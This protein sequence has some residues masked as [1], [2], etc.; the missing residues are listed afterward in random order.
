MPLTRRLSSAT[1]RDK[2]D[3]DKTDMAATYREARHHGP[4]VLHQ[5]MEVVAA[6][7]PV[8]DVHTVLDLGCGTGRYSEGLATRLD[9]DVI[10]ID[11]S[12]KMLGDARQNLR[13]PRVFYAGGSAESIPLRTQSVDLIFMSMVFHHF[14]DPHAVAREC[15]RVLRSGGRVCLRTASR[16]KI[17]VYPYVPYFPTSIPLLEQRLP[18]LQFQCDV[19]KDASFK[20]LFA[21]DVVQQIAPDIATYADKIALKADS[22]LLS[23][24]DRDFDKGLEALRGERRSGPVVEPIDF[25]VFGR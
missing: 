7:V 20:I 15:D 25:V 12:S 6:Q 21:G 8:A 23:L 11:P 5:W 17:S 14:I 9:A 19:F 16:E 13:H 22:I 4:E 1:I 2:M 10:G 18:S 3:Y 24:D